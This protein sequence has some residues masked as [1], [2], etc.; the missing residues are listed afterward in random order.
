MKENR[1]KLLFTLA[2]CT[3]L[4]FLIYQ[5]FCAGPINNCV[6]NTERTDVIPDKQLGVTYTSSLLAA[7]SLLRHTVPYS[8]RLGESNKAC[9]T[10]TEAAFTLVAQCRNDE[11]EE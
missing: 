5:A 11:M 2:L 3:Y 6:R 1:H 7:L 4:I 10:L 8:K 9:K